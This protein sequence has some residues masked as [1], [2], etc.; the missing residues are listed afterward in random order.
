MIHFIENYKDNTRFNSQHHEIRN[1]LQTA[2]DRGYNEHFHWGRFNWMM[3]SAYLDVEMLSKNAL[4]RNENGELAGAVLYDMGFDDRW[5]LIHA[6]SDENLLK[7]MI[8]Y[9]TKT[10]IETATIKANLN[11]NDIVRVA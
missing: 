6:I 3:A 7:Q 2:A 11:D 4:F 9:V 1:F 8:A 10:D 5:Y